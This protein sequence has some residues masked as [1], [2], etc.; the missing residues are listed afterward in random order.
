ML[1]IKFTNVN[2][3]DII[4]LIERGGEDENSKKLYYS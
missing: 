1:V 2:L 3:K 4:Y